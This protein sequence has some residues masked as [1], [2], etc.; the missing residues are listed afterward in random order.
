MP[1]SGPDE[2]LLRVLIADDHPIFLAGMQLTLESYPGLRCVAAV[3]TGAQAVRV[4]LAERPDV[5]VLDINMPDLS[6]VVVARAI[7]ADAPGVGLLMLTML[8]DDESVFAALRAG[9]RGY[10]LKGST[11]DEVV[12][13]IRGVAAGGAIFGPSIAARIV[14]YFTAGPAVSRGEA[15]GGAA[16]LPALSERERQVLTFLA[17]GESNPAIAGR[18]NLSPKTVRNHVSTIL[19]KLHVAD[20][21]QAMLRARDAGLGSPRAG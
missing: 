7:A 4:A 20:R 17:D 6:G 2:R 19:A 3:T 16:A 11:P 5:A 12:A 13:A 1:E 9:A 18:L 15:A 21:R 8:D 14:D 10:L